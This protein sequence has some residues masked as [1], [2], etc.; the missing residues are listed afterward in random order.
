MKYI[1]NSLKKTI[2]IP[3]CLR[4]Y[5]DE[6]KCVSIYQMPEGKKAGLLDA[7]GLI[8][9]LNTGTAPLSLDMRSDLLTFGGRSLKNFIAFLRIVS[10]SISMAEQPPPWCQ[11]E[12]TTP[13]LGKPGKLQLGR[14]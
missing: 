4:C 5:S 9:R 10:S 13:L 8:D 3:K 11:K 14:K 7:P 2:P 1:Q 6:I 12:A